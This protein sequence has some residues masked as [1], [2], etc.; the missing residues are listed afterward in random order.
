MPAILTERELARL[1]WIGGTNYRN[2]I[3]ILIPLVL[4]VMLGFCLSFVIAGGEH[5]AAAGTNLSEI[6]ADDSAGFTAREVYSRAHVQAIDRFSA[7]IHLFG[8]ALVAAFLGLIIWTQSNLVRRILPLLEADFE[9]HNP[10][11][12]AAPAGS[13]KA[14][15]P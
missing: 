13:E 9:K 15:V 5:A 14:S 2:L 4:C 8:G 6:L 12:P 10:A 3:K 11:A 1:R 7:A